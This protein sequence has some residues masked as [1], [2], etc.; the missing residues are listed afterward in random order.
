MDEWTGLEE[1]KFLMIEL[2]PDEERFLET[3]YAGW[4]LIVISLPWDC[5]L[6]F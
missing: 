5:F 3:N 6:D 2:L 1:A 4:K